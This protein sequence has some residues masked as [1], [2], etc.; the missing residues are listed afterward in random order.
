MPKKVDR[1]AMQARILDA[2]LATFARQGVQAATM[3]QIASAAGLGK[4]TLYLYFANK[5]LLTLALVTRIMRDIEEAF[6]EL[7]EPRSV[8]ALFEAIADSILKRGQERESIILFFEAFGPAF[9][10]ERVA[11]AIG[12]PFERIGA[13]LAAKIAALQAAGAAEPGCDAPATGRA[14]AA[15]IDGLI[16]HRALFDLPQEQFEAMVR[17]T[18]GIISAGLEPRTGA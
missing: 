18:M 3:E 12:E 5:E 13:L 1:E 9:R 7:A 4:G 16:L 2:V 14:L 10:D 8:H 11:R 15:A 6:A 17:S